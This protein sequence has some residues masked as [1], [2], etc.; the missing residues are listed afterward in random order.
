MGMRMGQRPRITTEFFSDPCMIT[1]GDDVTI[2]G[3][4]HIF[5]HYGGAGHLVIAPVVIGNRATIGQKA[6]IM[7]DVIIEDGATILAHSVLLPGTR[8][9]AGELW[10]GVPAKPIP[11]A[12]W[13][14]YKTLIEQR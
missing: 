12:E 7:G 11:R 14:H 9:G 13:E 8:V 2:G 4:A 1:L 5:C 3:S 10:G 6:T